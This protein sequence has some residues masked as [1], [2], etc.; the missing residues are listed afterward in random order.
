MKIS[1]K[2]STYGMFYFIGSLVLY[3]FLLIASFSL[4]IIGFF[5]FYNDFPIVFSIIGCGVGGF[6]G[7][8]LF[9]LLLCEIVTFISTFKFN[10]EVTNHD[11]NE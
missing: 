10:S 2:L 5:A 9:M 1:E 3:F 8:L 6:L 7:G 11:D 4:P